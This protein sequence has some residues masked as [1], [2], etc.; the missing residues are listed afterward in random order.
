M[1]RFV[2]R[3]LINALEIKE[4]E[5]EPMMNIIAWYDNGTFNTV[6]FPREQHRPLC[7]FA[8]GDDNILISPASVDLGGVFITPQEKDFEKIAAQDIENI[9]KE[10]CIS[11]AKFDSIIA[12][13]TSY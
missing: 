10:V 12:N 11:D 5:Q 1:P 9:L 8:E 7:F 3:Y 4:G 2:I 6:V 13:L